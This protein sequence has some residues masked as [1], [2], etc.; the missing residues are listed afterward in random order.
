MEIDVIKLAEF[1][2]E[3]ETFI[4]GIHFATS[5]GFRYAAETTAQ[6]YR[7]AGVEIPEEFL[8]FMELVREAA[9]VI[10]TGDQLM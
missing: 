4:D 7:D 3:G 5:V 9:R 6:G 2:A 1:A 10:Y 8:Q